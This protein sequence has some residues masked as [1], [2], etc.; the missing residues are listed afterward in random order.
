MAR[1]TGRGDKDPG[2]EAVI[3]AAL[4]AFMLAASAQAQAQTPGIPRTSE[5][6]PDFTG[7]WNAAWL[8]SLERPDGFTQRDLD[9]AEA[10]R[11]REFML[12]ADAARVAGQ[13]ETLGE[14]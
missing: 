2:E 5:G 4:L 10:A 9:E 12:S 7:V 8:N 3:R 1:R 11:L 13:L 6:R 14:K